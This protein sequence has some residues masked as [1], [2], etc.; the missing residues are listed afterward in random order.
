M[1]IDFIAILNAAITES[2]GTMVAQQLAT[3]VKPIED[4]AEKVHNLT[5]RVAALEDGDV[6]FDDRSLADVVA[7]LQMDLATQT[8]TLE[9][10]NNHFEDKV[11]GHLMDMI[12]GA[13]S[14]AISDMD[15]DGSPLGNK[16]M[17]AVDERA[18]SALGDIDWTAGG[19]AEA[20]ESAVED[21]V[22]DYDFE[23]KIADVIGNGSFS[24]RFHS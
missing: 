24:V 17:N 3:I 23:S 5:L 10:L 13:V 14:E 18:E 7:G 15:L 1:N 22:R 9:Y 8:E 2:V 20:M 16:I 6:K 4:M 19:A 11:R 21:A 12:D